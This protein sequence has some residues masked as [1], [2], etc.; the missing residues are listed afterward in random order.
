MYLYVYHDGSITQQA[1]DPTKDDF[2]SVSL[3]A[4]EI[5]RIDPISGI[6]QRYE[7]DEDAWVDIAITSE[8]ANGND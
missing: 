1:E 8:V 3:G 7:P 6:F 5:A 2:D 4:I